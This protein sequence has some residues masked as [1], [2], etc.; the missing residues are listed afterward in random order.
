[1]RGG[2]ATVPLHAVFAPQPFWA[3]HLIAI[4]I[5]RYIRSNRSGSY[6]GSQRLRVVGL[7]ERVNIACL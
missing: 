1:L 4:L 5:S 2:T 3:L 6:F 7:Q